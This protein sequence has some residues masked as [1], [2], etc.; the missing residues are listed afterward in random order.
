[1]NLDN[2]RFNVNLI[3]GKK[4]H[5]ESR[6]FDLKK[7]VNLVGKTVNLTWKIDN[8]IWNVTDLR[9]DSLKMFRK[10]AEAMKV[11]FLSYH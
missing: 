3:Q 8:F 11:R 4:I 1:M 9:Y 10:C 7:N 6:E 2:P 5:L